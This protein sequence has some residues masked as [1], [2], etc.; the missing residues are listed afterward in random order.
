MAVGECQ[1]K[2]VND[3]EVCLIL[4]NESSFIVTKLKFALSLTKKN[5]EGGR[6][7][8]TTTSRQ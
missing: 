8:C 4:K 7:R 6:C 1:T 2:N 3:E 5:F